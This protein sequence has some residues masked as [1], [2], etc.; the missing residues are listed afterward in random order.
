MLDKIESSLYDK[1]IWILLP[2]LEEVR[3]WS[4]YVIHGSEIVIVW[5]SSTFRCRGPHNCCLPTLKGEFRQRLLPLLELMLDQQRVVL[6]FIY[7]H[8]FD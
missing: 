8:E 1:T 2:R 3:T 6:F 5:H 7:H 4:E